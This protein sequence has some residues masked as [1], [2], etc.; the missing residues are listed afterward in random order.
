MLVY[1]ALAEVSKFMLNGNK[2]YPMNRC[3]TRQTNLNGKLIA[4]IEHFYP[5]RFTIFPHIHPF[6]RGAGVDHAR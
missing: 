1:F 3:P 5:K 4:F 6:I 2:G